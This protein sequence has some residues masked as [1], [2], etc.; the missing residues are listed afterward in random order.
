MNAKSNGVGV[1]ER[2]LMVS[3]AGPRIMLTLWMRPAVVRFSVATLAQVGSISRVVTAPSS[4]TARASQVVEYLPV[5]V[6]EV[7]YHG[8][9]QP[10]SDSLPSK[11]ANLQYLLR[12][13]RTRKQMQELSLS[14]KN[15]DVHQAVRP[16]ILINF[17][18][19]FILGE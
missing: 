10:G 3:A 14:W 6:R 4:G 12:A 7:S 18:E 5:G 11:R 16:A 13:H 19:D 9:N 17:L 2:F 15:G 8:Q 1:G